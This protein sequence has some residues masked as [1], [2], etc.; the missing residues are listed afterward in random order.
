MGLN[1]Q[2]QTAMEDL[3]VIKQTMTRSRLQMQRLAVLFFI[4]GAVQLL[5]VG[6]ASAWDWFSPA[7]EWKINP[8]R[9]LW[10]Y[11]FLLLA[12]AVLFIFWRVG[13]KKTDNNFTLY[14]YDMWGYALFVIPLIWA[15]IFT[16]DAISPNF[17]K[18]DTEITMTVFFLFAEQFMF[19]MALAT[20]GF[21]TDSLDWKI[22]SLLFIIA[23][24]I[25]FLCTGY[26]DERMTPIDL[27]SHWLSTEVVW[28]PICGLISMAHGGW[29]IYHEKKKPHIP[30]SEPDKTCEKGE[31]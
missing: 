13:L 26:I 2:L 21:L 27:M 4:C 17:L 23:Y 25:S 9:F 14:L 22:L 30:D 28:I 16:V 18:Q 20:T 29:L 10:I 6:G 31:E 8:V 1:E 11:Q 15:V 3:A 5:A 12:I 24:F 7:P 19:L